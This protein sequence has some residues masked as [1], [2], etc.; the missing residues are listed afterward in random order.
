MKLKNVAPGLIVDQCESGTRLLFCNK[1][2]ADFVQ[3][4]HQTNTKTRHS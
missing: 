3:G 4:V 2:V 1:F